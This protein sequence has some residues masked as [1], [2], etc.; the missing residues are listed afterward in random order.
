MA[1]E[2]PSANNPAADPSA[3]KKE[4]VRITLPPKPDDTPMVKRETV[5]INAPGVA[6]KKET[7][8]IGAPTPLSGTFTPVPPASPAT[9]PLTPPPRPPSAIPT[10]CA[11][12]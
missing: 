11:G 4:T 10:G 7:T 9:R 3:P 1:D 2:N 5:R 6:P 12:A 8:T